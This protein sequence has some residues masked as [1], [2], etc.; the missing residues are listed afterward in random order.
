MRESVF[1]KYLKKRVKEEGGRTRKLKW[2]GTKNAPDRMVFFF[3]FFAFV[4]LKATGKKATKAQAREHNKLRQS[5]L[6]VYVINSYAG[7]E[8]LIAGAKQ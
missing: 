6:Q 4:E 5:G 1:E 7:V 8:K 2:I 3:L